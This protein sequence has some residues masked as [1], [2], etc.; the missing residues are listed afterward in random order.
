MAKFGQTWWGEKWLNSLTHIDYSNRLP[1][2]RRYAGNGSVKDISISANNIT[3]KVKGTRNYKVHITIPAFSQPAKQTL[4]TEISK[5]PLIL[6]KLINRELPQELLELANKNNIDIF[7]NSWR[8]FSMDCSCP[9]WAVPCKHLAAVIYIIANE[10]DKNP[11]MVFNL[12]NLDI[13]N[14]LKQ[15]GF[16][17]NNEITG[18]P[19]T[20]SLLCEKEI[21]KTTNNKSD[22]LVDIDLSIIPNI[23]E[24]ILAVLDEQ[25]LFTSKSFKPLLKNAYTSVARQIN[26][27]IDK[28]DEQHEIDFVLDYEIFQNVELIINNDFFYF[29]TI[30]YSDKEEKHFSQKNG[31]DKLIEYLDAIPHKYSERLSTKLNALYNIYHFSIKLLQQ[32]AYIPQILQ[33]TTDGYIIRQIPALVNENVRT[34]F[35]RLVEL[36]PGDLVK[37]ADRAYKTKYISAREQVTLISSLF[38]DSFVNQYF[39]ESLP[40][41]SLDDKISRLFFAYESFA[42]DKLGEKETHSAIYKWLSKFSIAQLDFAPLIKI[43]EDGGNNFTVELF[44]ENRK[45][46]LAEPVPLSKFMTQKKYINNKFSVYESL[47]NLSNHFVD[48]KELIATSGKKEL[49]YDSE[50]FAAIL[51]EIIPV[52]KL[53][54]INILL[55]NSLKSLLRPK[56]SLSLSENGS[57]KTEKS[58]L[59]LD[60]MLEFQWQI[61]IGDQNISIEEF[62]KL[63]ANLSGVVKIKDQYVLINQDEVQKLLNNLEKDTDLKTHELLQAA[64]TEEYKSAKINISPKAKKIITDLLKTEKVAL[65]EHLNATLRPYQLKG[66]EWLY[67]NIKVGFGSIIADDMGLGKTLQVIAVILKLKQEKALVKQK[68][69][70]IVPTTLITN[71]VKE[72]V[73]FAPEIKTHVYHGQNRELITEDVDMVITTYGL[74]RSDINV[75]SKKKW[76]IVV[77]DEAQNI[78]NPGTGQT[79]AIKKIKAPV[80]IAMSGTPVEN[81]LSEYWS[82]SDFANKN[83]LGTIKYFKK[84]FANPIELDRDHKKLDKF[85]AIT[86]PFIIRRL[87]TD[88]N[89]ISDLPDKVENNKFVHLTKQQTAIYQNVVSNIMAEISNTKDQQSIQRKGLVFKLMTALKQIC[90]HPSQFL[91]KEEYNP[92]LS[93]KAM[94]LINLLEKIYESNEKVLIFTQYKEMGDILEKIIKDKFQTES[95]FLHGGISRKKRDE[96]VDD[97][98][99]KKHIKTFILSIKA[100]GTGLNLTAANHVIHYDLWW[101]PAVENQATD[102]AFRIGQEK[103]VMVYRL[104]TEGT[105]EEKI[106]EML[107]SK[108]ELADLTVATGE[109]WIGDLSNKELASLVDPSAPLRD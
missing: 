80:K 33:L 52:V 28:E 94:M 92:E 97:F 101:N 63:V 12:H 23:K 56:T 47:S 27:F 91:K 89:V 4:I 95:L 16:I 68:G 109:K 51:L 41:K 48:V 36:Q 15:K 3:A 70:V 11:F 42:F 21:K 2:G 24:N 93:G 30:F 35:E 10:I 81:R 57:E 87:K 46:S 75:L 72:I 74:I 60:K 45:N 83:Y 67:K 82:I 34:V 8:D 32:S 49:N 84:E 100:G 90:N 76:A 78:K 65:P 20:E 14:E 7:P 105:F 61:A 29:D 5:N 43:D 58:Y 66:Y 31:I 9:D 44:I 107:I 62:K 39:G 108:K 86:E 85:K 19:K 17:S 6:A 96:M 54:G 22:D 37:V 50:S 55:P 73:K 88:K 77:I 26:R 102:R 38:L 18:I 13:Y 79:K 1:R 53:L 99:N 25:T 103:R 64:L 71:W 98:Q 69:L 40:A 106:N 59:S 104:I